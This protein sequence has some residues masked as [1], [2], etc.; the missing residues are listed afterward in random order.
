VQQGGAIAPGTNTI[1]TNKIIGNLTLGGNV[2]VRINRSGF[3]SDEVNV[4]GTP[5]FSGTVTSS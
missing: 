2:N 1:G 5:S 3:A 4:T